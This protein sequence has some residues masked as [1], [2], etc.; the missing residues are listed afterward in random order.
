MEQ[1]PERIE[2]AGWRRGLAAGSEREG[3]PRNVDVYDY[4]N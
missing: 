4:A 3:A 1:R 2:Q